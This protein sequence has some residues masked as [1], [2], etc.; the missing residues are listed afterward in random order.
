MKITLFN[1]NFA[2]NVVVIY[3]INIPDADL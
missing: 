2:Y 1:Q 3:E